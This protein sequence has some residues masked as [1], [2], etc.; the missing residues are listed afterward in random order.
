MHFIFQAKMINLAFSKFF[1]G[2]I[3]IGNVIVKVLRHHQNNSYNQGGLTS[4][5]YC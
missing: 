4:G 2:P 1:I 3:D 5:K